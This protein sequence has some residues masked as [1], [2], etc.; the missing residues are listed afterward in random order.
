VWGGKIG[1]LVAGFLVAGDYTQFKG[2]L[3]ENRFNEPLYFEALDGTKYDLK[4]NIIN[5]TRRVHLSKI[6]SFI[7]L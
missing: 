4:F 3:S 6:M 1:L 2:P 5:P 7:Q